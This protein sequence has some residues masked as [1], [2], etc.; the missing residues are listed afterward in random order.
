MNTLNQSRI[1]ISYSHRGNGLAWKDQAEAML[2]QA[3]ER[4]LQYSQSH[5]GHL[6]EFDSILRSYKSLLSQMGRSQPEIQAH[7]SV[8]GKP[9]GIQFGPST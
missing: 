2:R 1:F 6:H 5:G 8:I 9:Y 3:V 7:L 4:C